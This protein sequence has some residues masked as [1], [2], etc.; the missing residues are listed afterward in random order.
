MA[1]DNFNRADSALTSPWTN[2]GAFSAV[3]VISNAVGNNTGS[4]QDCGSYFSTSTSLSSQVLLTA[5]GARN[6]GPAI[7]CSGDDGYL[8]QNLG[9]ANFTIY[10]ITNG[11]PVASAAA[12]VPAYAIND[13]LRLRRSGGDVIASRNGL[14]I[15]TLTDSTYTGG[16]PGIYVNDQNIRFDDWTDGVALQM[17]RR[18]YILP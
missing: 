8:L 3:S 4:N 11:V 2:W 1:S 5:T 16:S 9:G 6:G 18:I 14:D 10:K 17:G 13:V 15:V 12:A 7:N